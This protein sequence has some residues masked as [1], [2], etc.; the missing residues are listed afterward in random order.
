MGG[1]YGCCSLFT[2]FFSKREEAKRQ[3]RLLKKVTIIYEM[4]LHLQRVQLIKLVF[5]FLAGNKYIVR[6]VYS[7]RS[8]LSNEVSLDIPSHLKKQV[9]GGCALPGA[10][11]QKLYT[12][13]CG[14]GKTFASFYV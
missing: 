12:P 6:Y 2:C 1:K 11:K 4:Y 8:G 13:K 5:I 3:S 7:L 10:D 14:Q 9:R